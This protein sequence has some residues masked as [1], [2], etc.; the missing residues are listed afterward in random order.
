MKIFE[1]NYPYFAI[2]G[3]ENKEECMKF[4]EEVVCDVEDKDDFIASMKELEKSE[5]IT[6]V[7]SSVSEET[8]KSIGNREAEEQISRCINDNEPTL[9]AVD[10]SL[11]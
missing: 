6:K 4:Y 3:A 10:G 11:V 7:A 2:I 5:A 1:M 8:G 9:L